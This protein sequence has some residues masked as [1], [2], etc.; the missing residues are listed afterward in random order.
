VPTKN[1]GEDEK[2]RTEHE[3]VNDV[4][5]CSEDMEIAIIFGKTLCKRVGPDSKLSLWQ[6]LLQGT[7]VRWCRD[8]LDLQ[9]SYKSRRSQTIS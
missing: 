6:F 5:N 1:G 3:V 9:A 7:T 4:E 8:S 2:R